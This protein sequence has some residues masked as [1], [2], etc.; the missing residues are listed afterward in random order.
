MEIQHTKINH[1]D[2]RGEIRDILTHEDIDAVTYLTITAGSVRGNHYHE[3]S[4][5]WD[6]VL[7]GSIECYGRVG[8]D[9]P[10]EKV[11]ITAGD[12]VKHP[13]GECHALKAVT[14]AA[15]LSLTK[16]PRKGTDYE[17]DVIR[18]KEPLVS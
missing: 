3:H 7:S 17:Q 1:Q 16:G 10:I 11:V 5:Q 13:I 9:G 15:M 12:L 6:Y 8:L 2:A 4:V 14:D 18:L